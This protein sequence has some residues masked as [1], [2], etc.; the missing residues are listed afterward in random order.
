MG[1]ELDLTSN[2]AISHAAGIE[3][4]TTEGGED[5]VDIGFVPIV[6]PHKNRARYVIITK[7]V[8]RSAEPP[9]PVYQVIES[10]H[11]TLLAGA[12]AYAPVG[13]VVFGIGAMGQI[14]KDFNS[15]RSVSGKQAAYLTPEL[16]PP[17]TL[18]DVLAWP[19]NYTGDL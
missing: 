6:L 14:S 12:L 3:S 8:D 17:N 13:P 10:S 5:S 4:G 7:D 2:A 9:L 19:D 1:L 16:F 18:E 11:S 15:I